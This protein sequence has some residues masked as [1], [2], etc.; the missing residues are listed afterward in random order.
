VLASIRKVLNRTGMIEKLFSKLK[1]LL[2][3]A[4]TQ[5]VETLWAEIGALLN[6]LSP[7]EC[8]NYFA[9]CRYVR[10]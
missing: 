3:K 5:T 9:S 6:T 1:A 10:T 8:A 2:R 7:N 4:A